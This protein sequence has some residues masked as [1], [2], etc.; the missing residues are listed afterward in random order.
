MIG[1][2]IENLKSL[3]F[4]I[5]CVWTICNSFVVLHFLPLDFCFSYLHICIN[6][7]LLVFCLD[8][9]CGLYKL[10]CSS[11]LLGICSN[12]CLF[13]SILAKFWLS[14]SQPSSPGS[15]PN[16]SAIMQVSSPWLS[17]P[18]YFVLFFFYSLLVP[19]RL[20]DAICLEY[21][22]FNAGTLR[23]MFEEMFSFD[24]ESSIIYGP[25]FCSLHCQF[26]ISAKI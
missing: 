13:V 6:F 12:S 22:V 23:F 2:T 4:T 21:D 18:Y 19:G 9:D 16:P 14:G 17:S 8:V 1:T 20:A 7:L 10:I 15:I 26:F 5:S 11:G 3:L 24:L 25:F